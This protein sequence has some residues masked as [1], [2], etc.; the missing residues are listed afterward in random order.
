[1]LAHS[2][3]FY[4]HTHLASAY[5]MSI[6]YDADNMLQCFNIQAWIFL[7][8]D[9]ICSLPPFQYS[10]VILHAQKLRGIFG[11]RVETF[12]RGKTNF[13]EQIQL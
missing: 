6:L 8:Q 12:S 4:I 2:V 1:M 3:L 10:A 13:M 9:H 5:N 7:Y 11:C